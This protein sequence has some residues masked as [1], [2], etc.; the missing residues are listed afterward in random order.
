M[1]VVTVAG[2]VPTAAEIKASEKVVDIT[3]YPDFG[4]AP[5][6]VE[7]TTLTDKAQ[8]FVK[9]VQQ[10]DTFEFGSNYTAKDL[11]DLR[12]LEAKGENEW[13]AVMFGEDGSKVPDGHDGV[14][15][16]QGGVTA[17]PTSGEVNGARGMN[18]VFSMQT[19]P[20]FLDTLES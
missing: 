14:V 3:S 15:F 12:A 5:E 2:A 13:W 20:D 6:Q 18:I 19:A 11:K 8:R 1:H 16:W 7:V 9:G 4:G 10:L 17:Y